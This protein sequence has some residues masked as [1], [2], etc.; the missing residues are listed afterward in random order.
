MSVKAP[1]HKV[2]KPEFIQSTVKL[3]DVVNTI[4]AHTYSFS[5]YI[6]LEELENDT[7]FE[8]SACIVKP[9]FMEVFLSLVERQ[10]RN[11]VKSGS[12]KS[13][14]KDKTRWYRDLIK[15]HKELYCKHAGYVPPKLTH[16]QQCA[17]YECTKIQTAY[18]NNIKAHFGNR[19][20]Q[21]LNLICEKKKKSEEIEQR[22]KDV[23]YTKEAI[24]EVIRNSVTIPCA[25]I[26]TS[27]AKKQLPEDDFLD[28]NQKSLVATR[29]TTMFKQIP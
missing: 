18:I 16:A 21:V 3:V 25:N 26:K 14:L 22:M 27:V 10:V 11:R 6:F 7:S 9:F 5:K 19:L 24:K 28:E 23:R 1:I 29:F 17:D 4:T 2:V 8:L 13:R 15:K 20:R 12:G